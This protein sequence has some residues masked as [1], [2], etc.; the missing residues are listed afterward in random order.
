MKLP[1]SWLKEYIDI[2]L[3]TPK[4]LA[5]FAE[6]M[7]MSGSKVEK[8]HHLG[9]EITNVIVGRIEQILP[10]PNADKLVVTQINIG[11]D[12]LL[13]IVT[14]ATNIKE[15]DYIPV[16]V[17][18]AQLAGDLKI[19]KGKIR[20][21]ASNGML[22]S[23]EELGYT[24]AEYPEAPED[25]IYIFDEPKPLGADARSILGL[26]ENVIEFEI[27]TNRPDCFSVIGMVREAIAVESGEWRVE[28]GEC[29]KTLN[30][31]LST[32]NS[33]DVEIQNPAL[34]SRYIGRI[35]ENIKVEPSPQWMR[36]RLMACGIRP[37]NNIVD[38]TNYVML[39]YGQPMHAFDIR[40]VGGGK[41]IVRNA[42]QGEKITT[43]DGTE[44]VLDADVLVIAD[45]DKPIGIAGIM[46]GEFSK[47]MDDTTTILFESANFNGTHIRQSSKKLG[48]RTDSS[49]RYEKGLDPNL[50]LTCINRALELI[51]QLGYGDVVP[52]MVDCYPAPRAPRQLN[53]DPAKIAGLI[54]IDIDLKSIS[55][56][57]KSLEIE[58]NGTTATIPTFRYDIE[59]WEDLAEEVAR[60]Y[61]YDKIPT[62]VASSSNVGRKTTA[63]NMDDALVNTMV[64]LGYSQILTYAF[65]SPK[66]FDKL[67]IPE[68]SPLRDVVRI[69]NPLG[70][71]TS[72]MRTSALN[73]LL[74]SL[75]TNFNRRNQSA[76]LFEMIKTYHP[77]KEDRGQLPTETEY[78]VIGGYGNMDFYGIKGVVETIYAAFGHAD[79]SC[80]SANADELPFMHPGRTATFDNADFCGQLHPQVLENYEIGA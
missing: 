68:D 13:Q 8:I 39:E 25:G 30:S 19:K 75:S 10:H 76:R 66:V 31:Q 57:L 58:V 9:Q 53:F 11:A 5:D 37:I 78:L 72:I 4:H 20:G 67:L 59:I 40:S 60:I 42:A 45:A 3:N 16:A 36:S 79:A 7:T 47:I 51:E 62:V 21:E 27:T 64:S 54:G 74:T 2:D 34:C 43:L 46:G 12:E 1:I 70:E 61:G 77:N 50:A 6:R 71:D 24:R 15:G 23:I 48:M 80:T 28:S 41:I 63:Q 52:G 14:G 38:I 56:I 55:N 44:R 26:L 65:E 32:L 73:G 18:G 35:V 17:H 22:C 33:I 29:K 69:L 49:G